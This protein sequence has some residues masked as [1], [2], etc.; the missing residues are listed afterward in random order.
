[1]PQERQMWYDIGR[2]ML[3]RRAFMADSLDR[4]RLK[5]QPGDGA[6]PKEADDDES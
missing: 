2:M 3:F 6:P 1:M 5:E 4:Y